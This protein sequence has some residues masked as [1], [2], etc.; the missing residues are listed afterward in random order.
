MWIGRAQALVSASGDIQASVAFDLSSR[1]V[2]FAFRHDAFNELMM[3]LHKVLA[4]AELKAPPNV[5]GAFI[6]AG[7]SF[8]AFAAVTK[9]LQAAVKDILVVD[10]YMDEFVLTDFAGSIP[11]GVPLRLL[12]DQQTVKPSL[13]PAAARWHAQ[14]GNQRP[15]AVR[16]ALAKTL[17]DRVIFI[18]GKT[19]WI[20]TQSLKDF[21]K[22]SPAEI[23]R[24]DDTAAL[25]I[26]AYEQIW[27]EA[28]VIV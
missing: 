11:A 15:L 5:R 18:D 3:I 7:N 13:S 27:S 26:T 28:A 23:V 4:S 14:Y 9:V 24:A 2:Q 8:D 1:K 16:L 10:P 17:H 19:A 20:L 6:P 21:A 25:K 12:T 22:R